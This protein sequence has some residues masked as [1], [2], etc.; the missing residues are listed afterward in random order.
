MVSTF[1]FKELNEFSKSLNHNEYL[2]DTEHIYLNDE[3]A[4]KCENECVKWKE[5][6]DFINQPY[7]PMA[8]W[9]VKIIEDVEKFFKD[10]EIY[11]YELCDISK[12]PLLHNLMISSYN[13]F[14]SL[15]KIRIKKVVSSLNIDETI[16]IKKNLN[17]E[18]RTLARLESELLATQERIKQLKNKLNN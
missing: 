3:L 18:Y 2:I 8:S 15:E 17:Y 4:I 1:I 6:N 10:I 5:A 12:Y 14:I 11:K 16:E 9:P 7:P 13:R